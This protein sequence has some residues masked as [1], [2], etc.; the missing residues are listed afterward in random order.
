MSAQRIAEFITAITEGQIT[1]SKATVLKYT[2]DLSEN[3]QSEIDAIREDIIH[4]EVLHVDDTPIRSTQRFDSKGEAIETAV[5]KTFQV[6]L[7]TYSNNRS[8]LLLSHSRKNAEGVLEDDILP[9]F[10]GVIVSDGEF[11]YNNV[12]KYHANCNC[13]IGRNLAS[14]YRF[15]TGCTWAKDMANLFLEM[16]ARKRRDIAAGIFKMDQASL[17]YFSARYDEILALGRQQRTHVKPKGEVET[18]ELQ[19][20]NRLEKNKDKHL[21]FIRNYKVPFGNNQAERDFRWAK[22]KQKV[23]GCFRSYAGFVAV[24][25]GMSFISTLKKRK[26]P[27]FRAISDVFDGKQVLS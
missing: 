14:V 2:K 6:S 8:T 17:D 13:H 4:S 10:R 20:I 9:N 26:I 23:S 16:L 7:I 11:K 24:A 1:I 25:R 15:G 21:L 5:G 18:N 3:L 19:L 12:G 22:V 27:I